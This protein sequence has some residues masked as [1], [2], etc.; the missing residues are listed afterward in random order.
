M[1]RIREEIR[2]S[3]H[4]EFTVPQ[5]RI[6]D[7]LVRGLSTAAELAEY[8]GVSLAAISKMVDGLVERGL[9]VRQFK[10]GNRKQIFLFPSTKGKKLYLTF[11]SLAQRNISLELK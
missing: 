8:Q 10:S 6:M 11:R 3:S 5:L 1:R 4:S 2:S 9:V 7:Q